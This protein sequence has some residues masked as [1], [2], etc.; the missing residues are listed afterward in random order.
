MKTVGFLTV[1][2]MMT[3]SVCGGEAETEGEDLARAILDC[4]KA[5]SPKAILM[6][7]DD[8][9]RI[10]FKK[11]APGKKQPNDLLKMVNNRTAKDI[12]SFAE[13]LKTIGVVTFECIGYAPESVGDIDMPYRTFKVV[14]S[15]NEK[16][17]KVLYSF[18]FDAMKIGN[19]WK[20]AE[21]LHFNG[22]VR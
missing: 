7:M 19:S 10:K 8:I 1:I 5:A 22:A 11:G 2:L 3:V 17:S 20:Y 15:K 12:A 6:T 18:S 9:S 13:R 4:G 16:E 21:N 14:V